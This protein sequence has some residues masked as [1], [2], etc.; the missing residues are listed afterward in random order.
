MVYVGKSV[1]K[2]ILY[3]FLWAPQLCYQRWA[4]VEAQH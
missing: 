2:S 4:A 1:N 3:N